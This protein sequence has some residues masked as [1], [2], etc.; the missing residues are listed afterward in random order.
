[1]KTLIYLVE[2]VIAVVLVG[3]L[4][5]GCA[6]IQHPGA[7]GVQY[8]SMEV[9]QN[10]HLQDAPGDCTKTIH[11]EATKQAIGVGATILVVLGYLALVGLILAGGGR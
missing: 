1:M 4:F 9:C 8:P 11:S 5:A 10:Q 3:L 7:P 6:T 2:Q